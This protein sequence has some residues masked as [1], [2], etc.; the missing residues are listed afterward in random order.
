MA[1]RAIFSLMLWLLLACAG[2]AAAAET[3]LVGPQGEPMSLQA[4]VARARDGDT[5]EL[6]PGD[7]RGQTLLIEQRRLTLRGVGKRPVVHGDGQRS[8]ARALWTVRGGQVQ[9]QNIEFRGSR[10]QEA[11]GAGLRQ[12]G[13][14]LNVLDC[15]FNDNENGISA[16]DNAQAVL[17]IERSQFGAAPRDEGRLPHFLNVGRIA[18]LQVQ[19]SR[20]QDGFEGHMI[21]SRAAETRIAYNLLLDGDMGGSSYEIDL[22]VGGLATVI[23]NVI[24]QGP[25]SQNRVLIAYGS[26]G[27]RAWPKSAL[28]L[29]HNTLVNGMATPAWF[30]RVWSGRLPEDTAVLAVNNLIV[31]P[32]IFW[33]GSSGHFEGNRP[34]MRAM[35]TDA[36]TYAFELPPDSIWRG[37]GVDP[38]KVRGQDLS[39][40]AEFILPLGTQP[41]PPGRSSWTPGAFQK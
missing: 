18:R 41:L 2:V 5:I 27:D 37:R 23:G 24:A 29:A 32:G 10:S 35:L 16:I 22:P 1:V 34:A 17:T 12:E 14:E 30:L 6:L 39:P 36:S 7:Y 11:S 3:L 13:G 40:Q 38:R 4:A 25:K 33:L 28:H 26:E 15:V 19:G 20:F 8:S 31:G 9:V 21:K